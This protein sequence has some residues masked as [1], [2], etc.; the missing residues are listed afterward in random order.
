MNLTAKPILCCLLISP[1]GEGVF[2]W[3]TP[4]PL[5]EPHVQGSMVTGTA[6]V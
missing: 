2:N 4:N 6:K 1:L 3:G 5:D